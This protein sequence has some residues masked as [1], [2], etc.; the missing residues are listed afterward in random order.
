MVFGR[1]PKETTGATAILLL[2]A[3]ALLLA[4]KGWAIARL[5]VNWDEFFFLSHVH[6]L[7]RGDLV[8]PYQTAFT[9]AFRC[10]P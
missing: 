8:M 10:C 2:S 7:L 9:Q 1:H 5:N 4:W 3:C 6:A